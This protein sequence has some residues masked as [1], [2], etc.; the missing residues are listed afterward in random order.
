[1]GVKTLEFDGVS[2]AHLQPLAHAAI[3]AGE[4]KP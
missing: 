4:L 3:R 1:M 2:D